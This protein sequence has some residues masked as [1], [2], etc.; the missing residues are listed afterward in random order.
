MLN[1]FYKI[2]RGPQMQVKQFLKC[3]RQLLQKRWSESY[4]YILGKFLAVHFNLIF[5]DLKIE[6]ILV[7]R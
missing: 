4:K 5:L 7:L 2:E 3:S 1:I 6:G